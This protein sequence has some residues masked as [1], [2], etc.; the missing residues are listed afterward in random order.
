MKE[1]A[2]PLLDEA[3][4]HAYV[5]GRLAPAARAVMQARLESDPEAARTVRAWQEQQ[6]ALRALH[7]DV[8]EEPVPPTLL[9]AARRLHHRSSRLGQWQRWGGLAAAL[10]L[11]FGL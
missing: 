4:L 1:D 3:T 9:Q 10:L 8:L 2:D 11:A 5:D 7:R 6:D